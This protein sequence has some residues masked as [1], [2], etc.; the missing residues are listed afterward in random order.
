[1]KKSEKPKKV[2]NF[3]HNTSEP[4]GFHDNYMIIQHK[5]MFS[6]KIWFQTD[7]KVIWYTLIYFWHCEFI[8]SSLG[9]IGTLAHY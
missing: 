8:L 4:I 9:H 6:K 3:P 7:F 2:L 5:L 1:M